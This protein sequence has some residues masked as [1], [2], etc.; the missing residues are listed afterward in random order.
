MRTLTGSSQPLLVGRGRRS[1]SFPAT[2]VII[3]PICG[4]GNEAWG[5]QVPLLRLLRRNSWAWSLPFRILSLSRYALCSLTPGVLNSF[6]IPLVFKRAVRM[7]SKLLF[8]LSCFI[9]KY[10]RTLPSAG[11]TILGFLRINGILF[12][13]INSGN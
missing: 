2:A 11:V 9:W 6:L 7:V 4:W 10:I 8:P 12:Y 5:R 13:L 1:S 3:I